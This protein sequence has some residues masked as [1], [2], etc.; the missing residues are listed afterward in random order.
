MFFNLLTEFY[1]CLVL[2]PDYWNLT[3]SSILLYQ[4]PYLRSVMGSAR[5][6]SWYHPHQRC[7]GS[8]SWIA[9]SRWTWF[10]RIARIRLFLRRE[11]VEDR[12]LSNRYENLDL[13]HVFVFCL[14]GKKGRPK[15]TKILASDYKFLPT[16]YFKSF[17]CRRQIFWL[18][19]SY[20]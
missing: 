12:T 20:R 18:N 10:R 8:S 2:H 14:V 11:K 3:G 7:N 19:F 17:E 15:L 4:V 16:E 6:I 1:L 5:N 9:I 13:R